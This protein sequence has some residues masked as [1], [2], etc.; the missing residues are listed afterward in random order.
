MTT[1]A[2]LVLLG[3]LSRLIPHPPNAVA[4][5]ALALYAGARLP[6]RLALAVPLLAMALSDFF[7]DFG[8]GRAAISVTRVTIYATFAAIVFAGRSLA[9]SGGPGR[10][11]SFSIGASLLFFVTSNFAVWAAGSFYPRTAA[12]LALCYAAAVPFL[13]N[14]L[15]ADLAGTA[16]LFSLDALGRRARRRLTAATVAAAALALLATSPALAQQQPPVSETV[17]VTATLSPEEESLLGSAATV[18]TRRRIEA[19]GA[20]TVLELLR[21]V[22]GLDVARQG[23]DG[24]LTSVFLRGTSSTETLILVDGA[25]VNSPFFPGY[26]FS[27]LTTENIERIEIVRGPFSALYGSDAVGGVI[28]IFTRPVSAGSSGRATVEAGSAGQRQGSAFVSAGTG[29]FAA[30]ASYLNARVGGD[31]SNSDWRQENASFKLEVNPGGSLRLGLAGGILD[32]E[33]GNPGPVGQENL[34]ARSRFREERIQLPVSFQP[35]PDHQVNALFARVASK[36]NFRDPMFSYRSD[37]EARSLEARAGDTWKTGSHTVSLFGSWDR[38]D[39]DNRDT[40]GTALDGRVSTLWGAGV[41]DSVSIGSAWS[42]TAGVRYDRHSEFGGAWSPRVTASWLSPG[43]RW[44]ARASAGKAFR[45]PTVGELFYPFFGN[46]ALKPERETSWELGVE[47]YLGAGRAEVSLFW[48]DLTNLI[49]YDFA[50]SRNENIGRARTRGVEAAWRQQVLPSLEVEVGYTY[51]DAQDLAA[52]RPLLRRPAH[53]GALALFWRPTARL[54]LAP[55]A[56]FVG[57]RDDADA[58]T[59]TT[60]RSPS[61]I[62]YDLFLRYELP[63][64]APYARLENVTDRRYEEVNGYPAPRRRYAVGLELKI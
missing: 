58:I 7:L 55:R 36:P 4:L 10:L 39:V 18:I 51:L 59:F 1:A 22:P 56:V 11:A 43:S 49:V 62:R 26:D 6:R 64:V 15:F 20:T 12:G 16:V 9:R 19:S 5:G 40:F 25:R 46:A 57:R 54:S 21:S 45:A 8:S 2:L 33:S 61:F 42:A 30:S 35:A 41:Q 23:S 48:N 47:R 34:L 28:Q 52:G 53:R 37:T 24:G 50:R 44:K 14:T 32:G 27:A 29:P 31:R 60:V 38:Y 17:V 13:W 63:R 3:A